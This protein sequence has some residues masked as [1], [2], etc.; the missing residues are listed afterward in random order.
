MDLDVGE[1]EGR[2]Q[3]VR[4]ARAGSRPG[5]PRPGTPRCRFGPRDGMRRQRRPGAASRRP[6]GIPARPCRGRVRGG[7][8][9]R[10]PRNLAAR[11]VRRGTARRTHRRA[12]EPAHRVLVVAAATARRLPGEAGRGAARRA[13]RHHDPGRRVRRDSRA[14]ADPRVRRWIFT[15]HAELQQTSPRHRPGRDCPHGPPDRA[16]RPCQAGRSTRRR[17]RPT[18]PHRPA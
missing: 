12:A 8:R 18:V 6:R 14:G 3:V 2:P 15:L 9:R 10:G 13:G 11:R 7:Q 4:P 1:A 17:G 5:R 16:L